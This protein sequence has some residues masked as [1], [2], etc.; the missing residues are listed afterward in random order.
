METGNNKLQ[1]KEHS[2]GLIAI[3]TDPDAARDFERKLTIQS[4]IE[5]SV[6]LSVL[7]QAVGGRA[8]AVALDIQLTRLVASLNLKWNLNDGQIKT[9]VEDL[10]DKYPGE[11]LEDFI[12]CF[13]KARQGEYGELIRLDSPII[14]TWMEKYLDEKYRIIEDNLAKEKDDYYKTVIPENSDRDWLSEWQK[15]VSQSDGVRTVRPMTPKE[16]Q[17]EGRER[18]KKESYPSTSLNEIEIKL[19]HIQYIR[20]NY[21]ARTGQPLPGYITEK[22]WNEKQQP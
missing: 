19:R 13:K 21:D 9:I 7:K 8:V 16:I 14:F 6:P 15:A 5:K 20:E 3:V 1:L 2:T 22:E 10:L 11:S 4:V 12:L 17:S 18:P